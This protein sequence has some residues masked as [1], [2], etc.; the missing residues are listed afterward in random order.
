MTDADL[1]HNSVRFEFLLYDWQDYADGLSD[2]LD[3][4]RSMLIPEP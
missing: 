3:K 4:I 1:L 2:Y